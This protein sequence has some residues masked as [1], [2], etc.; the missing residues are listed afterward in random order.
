[1][2]GNHFTLNSICHSIAEKLSPAG[3]RI[4]PRSLALLLLECLPLSE[5]AVPK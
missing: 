3:F 5:G 2:L 4:V 1:M